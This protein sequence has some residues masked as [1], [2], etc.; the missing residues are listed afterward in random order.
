[1]NLASVRASFKLAELL[2]CCGKPFSDG[3][4]VKKCW[5]AAAEEVCPDKKDVLKAV[6]LFAIY[7][8]QMNSRNGG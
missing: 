8:H 3:E 7:S 1:M 6:S 5:S 4:F 2:A